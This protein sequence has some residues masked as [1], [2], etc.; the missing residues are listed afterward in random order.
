M[1]F[2]DPVAFT[3]RSRF[4]QRFVRGAAVFMHWRR[5]NAICTATAICAGSTQV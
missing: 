4:R 3:E 5:A 1:P 2:F